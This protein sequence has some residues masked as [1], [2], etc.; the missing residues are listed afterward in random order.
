[1]ASPEESKQTLPLS[2]IKEP[3]SWRPD[4][5]VAE[6]VLLYRAFFPPDE[7]IDLSN[8]RRRFLATNKLEP[9]G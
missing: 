5:D 7:Q 2:A 3:P 9:D 4:P 8:L 1:M 6:A